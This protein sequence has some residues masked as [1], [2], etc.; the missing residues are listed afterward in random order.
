M[1]QTAVQP[2]F[3]ETRALGSFFIRF[4][5]AIAF[6]A[7]KVQ[8]RSNLNQWDTNGAFYYISDNL[9]KQLKN[10]D[11]ENYL[12]QNMSLDWISSLLHQS[13][14]PVDLVTFLAQLLGKQVKIFFSNP[15]FWNLFLVLW[16]SIRWTKLVHTNSI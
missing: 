14:L 7:V 11:H 12:N 5:E 8:A 10:F 1:E 6:K 4:L 15:N 9:Q 13:R 16:N 3:E 2:F